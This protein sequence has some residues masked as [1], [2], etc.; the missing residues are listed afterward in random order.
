MEVVN[1]IGRYYDSMECNI[2]NI[3]IQFRELMTCSSMENKL[4]KGRM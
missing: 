2:K 4:M 1:F 3:L